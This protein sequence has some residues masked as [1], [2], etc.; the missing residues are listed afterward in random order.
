MSDCVFCGIVAGTV[1]ASVVHEDDAT[2][3][4]MDLRQPN[5]GHVLVIPRTHVEMI[6][7]LE[8]DAAARVFQATVIVANAIRRSLDP[9]GLNVWQSNGPA[10]AFQ[11][12]PHVHV[13]VHLLPRQ[14]DDQLIRIYPEKPPYPDRAA[15][16]EMAATIRA[17]LG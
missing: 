6:Y 1:P 8:A 9:P 5:P 7:D 15:L 2:L 4:F 12:V 16:N 13:H 17:G 11:E 14:H 3:A 10:V